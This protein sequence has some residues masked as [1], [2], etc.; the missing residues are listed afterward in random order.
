MFLRY[1]L[2]NRDDKP[3]VLKVI[4]SALISG[5]IGPLLNNPFDV[6]KT[7]YMNPAYNYTSIYQALK[8]IKKNEGLAA[9]W[10]GIHLRLFRVAG[11]QAITFCTIEQ[12]MYYTK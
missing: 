6:V 8:E 1:K 5:S 9:L 3:N 7:R 4:G 10:R 2:I 11:G 12:L